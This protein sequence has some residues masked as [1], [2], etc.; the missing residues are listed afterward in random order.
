MLLY[1]LELSDIFDTSDGSSLDMDCTLQYSENAAGK[2]AGMV[3]LVEE[4]ILRI[5]GEDVA[6]VYT[7][8]STFTSLG[9]Q[10]CGLFDLLHR[11][12]QLYNV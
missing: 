9:Q 6:T 4:E 7:H 2:T 1:E 11:Y 12:H 10:V 5:C 3:P 8:T